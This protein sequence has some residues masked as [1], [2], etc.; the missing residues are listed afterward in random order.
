M[1]LIAPLLR[2]RPG[3]VLINFMTEYIRRFIDHP[4]QQTQTSFASLFG[5]G[6]YR[7][8]LQGLANHQDREEACFRAYADNVRETG[9]F[10]YTCAAIVLHPEIDRSYFHLIYATRDRKGVEVFKDVE[11]RATV[12]MEQTRAEAKQRKRVKKSGQ[13]ELFPAEEMPHSRPIDSLRARY[14]AQSMHKVL[15]LLHAESRVAYERVWDLALSYPLVWESDLKHW[16]EVKRGEHLL[17]VDGMQPRQRVPRLEENN[18][19]VWEKPHKATPI[20]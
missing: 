10:K 19:L 8:R 2:Q 11:K 15:D 20:T 14:L 5:S 3:E 9:D 1:E 4:D 7:D 18:F 17:R 6:D 13:P 16:I 12:V